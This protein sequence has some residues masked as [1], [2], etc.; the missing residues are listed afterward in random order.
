MPDERKGDG[1][2]KGLQILDGG[3]AANGRGERT[4]NGD[5]D[6]DGCQKAVGVL[7]DR[8]D[9]SG[10]WIAGC[11]EASDMALAGGNNGQF[12]A[13]KKTVYQ[14]QNENEEK[15]VE[16]DVHVSPSLVDAAGEG[17]TLPGGV[18]WE[19]VIMIKKC[20]AVS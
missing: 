8:F 13:R 20:M 11:G 2:Q 16:E 7:L 19:W 17:F 18:E 3:G 9:E 12:G 15:F 4:D 10:L 6:L 5:P 1:T 14:D